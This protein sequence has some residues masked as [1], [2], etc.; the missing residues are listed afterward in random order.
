MDK[1]G[2]NERSRIGGKGMILFDKVKEMNID[3]FIEWLHEFSLEYVLTKDTIKHQL[4]M[5]V[6]E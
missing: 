6:T 2:L 1:R 3:E 5:E 4:E